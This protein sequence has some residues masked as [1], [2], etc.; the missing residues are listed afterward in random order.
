MRFATHLQI[1]GTT[2]FIT[3]TNIPI[4]PLGYEEEAAFLS[5]AC[6][7]VTFLGSSY[8]KGTCSCTGEAFNSG[9]ATYSISGTIS[10]AGGSGATVNLT[11]YSTATVTADAAGDYIFTSLKIGSYT[12]TPSKTGF[13]FHPSEPTGNGDLGE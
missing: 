1:T 4:A 8:G 6:L 11:G 5:N 9:A 10:G 2:T 12:V 3:E 7:L 13:T